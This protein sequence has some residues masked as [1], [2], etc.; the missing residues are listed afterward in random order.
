MEIYIAGYNL[1]AAWALAS[2]S[3][4]LRARPLRPPRQSGFQRTV[5]ELEREMCRASWPQRAGEDRCHDPPEPAETP[6][7]TQG[8]WGQMMK[9][10][11]QQRDDLWEKLG[12]EIEDVLDP[13]IHLAAEIA[14]AHDVMPTRRPC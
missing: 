3:P 4:S 6:I 13:T 14:S 2:W 1:P 7:A 8:L 10:K 11:G 5:L 9:L 12:R